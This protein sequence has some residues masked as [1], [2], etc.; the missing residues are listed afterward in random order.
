MS[1][2]R[3]AVARFINFLADLRRR[4]VVQTGTVY[5]VAL[6]LLAQGAADLFPAFGLPD[7]TVRAFVVLGI[8]G[9]PVVLLLSYLFQLT[10]SGLVRDHGAA[11][12]GHRQRTGPTPAEEETQMGDCTA[13]GAVSVFWDDAGG[14]QQK[15]FLS[16]FL[17]GRSFDCQVRLSSTRVSRHHAEVFIDE[18][19]WFLRD[20]GSANGTWLNGERVVTAPLRQDN[21]V[22]CGKEGPTVVLQLEVVADTE[23]FTSMAEPP[24]AAAAKERPASGTEAEGPSPGS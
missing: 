15:R 7:W 16:G 19:S 10:A 4:K 5:I 17:I 9:L 13:A 20:L 24:Q 1:A 11:D 22:Q 18:D 6:W 2:T 12:A 14:R 3:H 21:Q 8:A 23:L